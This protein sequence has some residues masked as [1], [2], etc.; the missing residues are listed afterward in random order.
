[1]IRRPPRS[2]LFP[3]TTLFRSVAHHGALERIRRPQRRF[4]MGLVEI[5]AD[6]SALVERAPVLQDQER[7]D[8]VGVELQERR[9]M[10]LH[11]REVDDLALESEA[12]LCEAEPHPARRRGPPAM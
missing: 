3:Y 11:L 12:L 1:M 7:N 8:A 10:V 9:R 2:T 6:R 5:L 4:G